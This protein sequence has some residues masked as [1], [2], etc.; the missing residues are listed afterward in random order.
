MTRPRRTRRPGVAQPGP[1]DGPAQPAAPR[2]PR[3]GARAHRRRPPRARHVTAVDVDADLNRAIVYYDSLS[4]EAGD[5]DVLEAFADA[6]GAPAGGHRPPAPRP[7]DA[8]PGVPPRRRAAR[9][10]AHRQDPAR[11]R[12]GAGRSHGVSRPRSTGWRSS[13]RRPGGPATTWWPRPAAMLGTAGRP[14]RHPRPR[15]HR[16][17]PARRRLGDAPAPL[18][19][20]GGQD[21][22]GRDRARHRHR[23]PRRRGRGDRHLRHV[24]RDARRRAGGRRPAPHRRHPPGAADGVGAEGRRP[25]PPRAGP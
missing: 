11:P 8:D 17:A 12:S 9:R 2:D 14:L 25:A 6:A 19:E 24:G 15:R 21:L 16:R 20:R 5:A 22:H 23:H 10:R 3:R 18:P 13:T 1:A 7:Q 4:G